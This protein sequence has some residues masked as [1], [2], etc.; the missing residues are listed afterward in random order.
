MSLL[1]GSIAQFDQLIQNENN[2]ITYDAS[3]TLLHSNQENSHSN[4]A[5]QKRRRPKRRPPPPRRPRPRPSPSPTPTPTP[6]PNPPGTDADDS[7]LTL[8]DGN[9]YNIGAPTNMVDIWV[10][11]TSGSD[12]ASGDSR[13]TA[14]RTLAAAWNRIPTRSTLTRGYHIH[15]MPGNL[16]STSQPNYWESKWG[17]RAAPI[18]IE[19]ADP[20]RT[21]HLA[22]VNVFDCRYLYF[23]N[24]AFDRE[25]QDIIHCEQCTAFLLRDLTIAGR[26]GATWEAVKINQCKGVY[27]ENCDISGADDNA[28]DIFA[29]EFGHILDSKMHNA[30]WCVYH[31]GGSAHHLVARNEI[32]SC[33]ESG[34]AAG[35]GGGL[36]FMVP[37]YLRYESYDIRV[38]N[39]YIHD[40]WGAGLGVYGS[41]H[42]EMAYNTLRKVGERSHAIEVLLGGRSC[43]GDTARC[44]R[45]NRMGGWGWDGSETVEIPNKGVYIANNIIDNPSPYKTQWQHITVQVMAA[46]RPGTNVPGEYANADVD[47]N[48]KGN[49]F[50]NG[51]ST[52]SIGIESDSTQCATTN[53][54]CNLP[55]LLADN[56]FNTINPQVAALTGRPGNGA[57]LSSF[58]KL[59]SPIPA[60]TSWE[61]PLGEPAG[62]SDNAVLKDADGEMRAGRDVPGW[63]LV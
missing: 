5:M 45:L 22:S 54:T 3:R 43:D 18:I 26:R 52:M 56:A 11:P 8:P 34:Y 39:N 53:P 19:G 60:W 24:L 28:V 44:S 12:S 30:N 51:D 48:V 35:Q 2:A 41:Y 9:V 36:E 55:Q 17:T 42:I 16:A 38:I 49:I 10:N 50:W 6:T 27:I 15:I 31:K 61:G 57:A 14:L 23:I 20:G 47:L 63:L 13:A 58:T 62:S 25:P 1:C 29:V 37:P 7:F 59:W 21:A 4:N 46:T 33:G 32:Y 40:V